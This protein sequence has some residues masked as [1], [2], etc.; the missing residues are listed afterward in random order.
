MKAHHT[1]QE[2]IVAA[3][4]KDEPAVY[5]WIGAMA[6]HGM[7]KGSLKKDICTLLHVDL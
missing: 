4:M 2:L 6:D 7:L 5:V 3:S 1:I